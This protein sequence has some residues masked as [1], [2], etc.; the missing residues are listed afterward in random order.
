MFFKP[1][2]VTID[3]FKIN[4]SDHLGTISFGST[5]KIGRNVSAKKSQG[6]G[7]QFADFTIQSYNSHS[8]LD[9]DILDTPE[10]NRND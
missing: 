6:F 1:N 4:N 9:D 2:N 3:A 10:S 5:V 7:Q 8:V